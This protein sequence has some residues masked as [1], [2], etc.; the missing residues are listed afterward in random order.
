M[1][2]LID[3]DD[4]VTRAACGI[5]SGF[6][7]A[8]RPM[9]QTVSSFAIAAR[10]PLLIEYAEDDPRLNPAIRAKMGDRS[11]ICVPLF[12]GERPVGALSVMSTSE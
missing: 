3:G 6:L 10:A 5:A 4:I 8:R 1:I 11:H 12:A 9:S 2:S 7:N